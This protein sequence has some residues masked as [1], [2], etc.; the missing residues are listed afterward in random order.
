ML[1]KERDNRLDIEFFDN[2]MIVDG[3]SSGRGT[4]EAPLVSFILQ[5]SKK[6]FLYSLKLYIYQILYVFVY[7]VLLKST[8]H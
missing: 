2:L 7:R 5:Y 1:D 3:D 4:G 6:N 8:V